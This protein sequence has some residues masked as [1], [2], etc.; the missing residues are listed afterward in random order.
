M[1]Q[2]K[3]SPFL[4]I[5]YSESQKFDERDKCAFI[6]GEVGECGVGTEHI[7]KD[8]DYSCLQGLIMAVPDE[9]NVYRPVSSYVTPNLYNNGL[10]FVYKEG[11]EE[12][13][14]K[15]YTTNKGFENSTIEQI[16]KYPAECS[17]AIHLSSS[18]NDEQIAFLTNMAEKCGK[19]MG[20]DIIGVEV[21]KN[22]LYVEPQVPL[23]IGESIFNGRMLMRRATD[24]NGKRC[25]II[26]GVAYG[27]EAETLHGCDEMWIGDVVMRPTRKLKELR[28]A[29]GQPNSTSIHE[30]LQG[31]NNRV[32]DWM[33]EEK[34]KKDVPNEEYN[35]L[36][37]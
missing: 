5:V 10:G 15:A 36:G 23:A 7:Q 11:E 4:F 24:R 29:S 37:C 2:G 8:I 6:T 26:S 17:I 12:A 16:G 22:E 27:E 31:K 9:Y 34:D 3:N 14:W 13:A 33:K 35:G 18:P 30:F 32:G 1:K 20:F 19:T 25:V 28:T 21:K